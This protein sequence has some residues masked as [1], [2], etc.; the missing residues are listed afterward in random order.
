MLEDDTNATSSPGSDDAQTSDTTDNDPLG[1]IGS[2]P[3][4]TDDTDITDDEQGQ[5]TQDGEPSEEDP[6]T[7]DKSDFEPSGKSYEELR[8]KLSEQGTEKN[9]YR[10]QTAELQAKLDE[11]TAQTQTSSEELNAY[12]EWYDKYYPVLD[13]LW[14]DEAL[15]ERIESGVQTKPL[16]EKDVDRLLQ[17]KLTEHRQQSEFEH[18]VDKWLDSH[19]DVKGPVAK[20]ILGYLEKYDLS[21]TPEILDMA[22]VYVNKDRLK[23]VGTK[24]KEIQEKKL[25]KA[26]VGGGSAKGAAPTV[27]D[28]MD[29]I[30]ARPSSSYY[31]NA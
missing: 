11:L 18:G 31:P 23:E 3:E 10:E 20:E 4:V 17:E 6:S 29:E 7:E 12:K 1:G 9:R 14:R 28:P 27:K 13:E 26:M 19:P 8:K 22:Y 16:S 15:R 24:K 2:T 30:F 25:S 21:P 5:L